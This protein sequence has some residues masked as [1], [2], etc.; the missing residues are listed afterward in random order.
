MLG[1]KT[2]FLQHIYWGVQYIFLINFISA[3]NIR[4]NIKSNFILLCYRLSH[5]EGQ[6]RETE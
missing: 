4:I 2:E 1:E 6:I 3:I 5:A